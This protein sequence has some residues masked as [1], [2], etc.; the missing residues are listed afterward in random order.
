MAELNEELS[1]WFE[2]LQKLPSE[3]HL[4]CPKIS[5]DDVEDYK[6]LDDPESAI[7]RSEKAARIEDGKRRIEIT[8]W[9]SLIFGFD[10]SA[11]G[12][13]LDEFKER[14]ERTLRTCSEC[15]LNWH[16][17]R[18]LQLQKF[19]ECVS[20]SIECLSRADKTQKMERGRHSAYPRHA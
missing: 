15:V 16:M 2:E 3:S 17:Y 13:W 19:S 6:S 5:E 9:N 20:T 18:P 10:K 11:A 8:Y 4:L 7:S 12:K 14:I 1:K